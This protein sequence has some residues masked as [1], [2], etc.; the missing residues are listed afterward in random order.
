MVDESLKDQ[1][2]DEHLLFGALSRPAMTAGV[3]YEMFIFNAMV[4]IA[5]LIV[6]GNLLYALLFIPFHVV[7]VAI[8]KF[9]PW[10]ITIFWKALSLPICRNKSIWGVKC[11]E[12]D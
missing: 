10:L 3:T 9:D 8:C 11:Y 7:G 12:P 1:G 6:T 4:A 2:L 5:A